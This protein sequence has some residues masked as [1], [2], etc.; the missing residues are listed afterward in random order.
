MN[1]QSYLAFLQSVPLVPSFPYC[2]LNGVPWP[3]CDHQ[4]PPIDQRIVAV[5][6]GFAESIIAAGLPHIPFHA[7]EKITTT[8]GCEKNKRKRN[9]EAVVTCVEIVLRRHP[10]SMWYLPSLNY[11]AKCDKHNGMFL[12]EINDGA[13]LRDRGEMMPYGFRL[14][15][16]SPLTGEIEKAYPVSRLS[17]RESS[18]E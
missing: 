14:E 3:D 2:D 18:V 4:E 7:G 9:R 16:V 13:W 15:W 17:L 10:Q 5:V 6:R 12:S 11:I 8:W 1:N